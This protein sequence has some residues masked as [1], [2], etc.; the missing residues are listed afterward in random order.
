MRQYKATRS[1]LEREIVPVE[2]E[3]GRVSVKVSRFNGQ[4]V[5]VAPEYED[6]AR[7]AREKNLPLKEVQAQAAFA[8]RNADFGFWK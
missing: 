5:N 8:L 4:V 2:T 7:L 1:I 3:Y 6:C